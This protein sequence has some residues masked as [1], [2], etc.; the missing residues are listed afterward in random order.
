MSLIDNEMVFTTGIM[1]EQ[2]V[3]TGAEPTDEVELRLEI[4]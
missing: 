3:E 1:E 4:M 2:E